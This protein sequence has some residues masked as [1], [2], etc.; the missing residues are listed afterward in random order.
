MNL[1]QY[2][3]AVAQLVMARL[4]GHDIDSASALAGTWVSSNGGWVPADPGDP[5]G[6][7]ATASANTQSQTADAI[8]VA[9]R[10]KTKTLT[11]T[12]PVVIKATIGGTYTSNVQIDI[13]NDLKDE[14]EVRLNAALAGAIG[15]KIESYTWGSATTALKSTGDLSQAERQAVQVEIAALA[16]VDPA[17]VGT[18]A[19]R[20]AFGL[21]TTWVASSVYVRSSTSPFYVDVKKYTDTTYATIDGASTARY[22]ATIDRTKGTLSSVGKAA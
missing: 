22:V 6:E 17:S 14:V 10:A 12:F 21:N 20:L 2:K 7:G 19:A 5:E 8:A 11:A 9:E 1:L 18:A 16:L 4:P 13:L 3:T 15:L